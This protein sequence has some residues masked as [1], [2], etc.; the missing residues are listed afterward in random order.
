MENFF[1]LENKYTYNLILNLQKIPQPVGTAM[2]LI[3]LPFHFKY[4]TIITMI[5]YL[6]KIISSYEV[7]FI[8]SSQLIIGGI[9][10]LVKRPRPFNNKIIDNNLI[11]NKEKM[12]LD[13]YSFPSGHTFNAF[14]LFYILRENGII[15]NNYKILAYLVGF[16]RIYLGV[17][18]LSDVIVGAVLAK[19]FFVLFTRS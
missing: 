2:N 9:K 1:K 6:K 8:L 3:S 4:Y 19:V 5:L 15:N 18:Y 7:A 16:S 10:H 13:N 17:H 14:L 11:K 12:K